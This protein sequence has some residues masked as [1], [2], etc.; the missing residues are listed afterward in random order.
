MAK[1][2]D[3]PVVDPARVLPHDPY[4]HGH[5]IAAW[6]AV[7]IVMVGFGVAS[8]GFVIPNVPLAI[9]GGVIALAGGPIGKILGAMG[10]GSSHGSTR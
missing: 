5:S 7:T 4:G 8:I 6:A 9:V 3:Q 2:T 10:L 1:T